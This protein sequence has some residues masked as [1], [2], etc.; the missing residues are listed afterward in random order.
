MIHL[1][2]D[3]RGFLLKEELKKFLSD[4]GFE[5]KDT[6]ALSYDKTDDYAD[7]ACAA[8]EEIAKS[9]E[10]DRGIFICGSGHGMANVADKFKG[11]R[12]ALAFN[13]DV[14]IQSREHENANVLILASDWLSSEEA[15]EIALVWLRTP[16]SG[17]ERHVRRLNEIKEIEEKNFK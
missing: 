4:S 7:F 17:E 8:A 14:A 9:P 2:A 12:A 16:F 10:R 13:K 6:G 3:H 11:L 15:K 5:V 1:A